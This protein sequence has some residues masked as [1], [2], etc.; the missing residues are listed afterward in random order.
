MDLTPA[1]LD[2]ARL[3]QKPVTEWQHI[4]RLGE[5]RLDDEIR[6]DDRSY[7]VGVLTSDSCMRFTPSQ[8]LEEATLLMSHPEGSRIVEIARWQT[9]AHR[10]LVSIG[11]FPWL[12]ISDQ[13]SLQS[14]LLAITYAEDAFRH[15]SV[16]SRIKK[17]ISQYERF[18]LTLSRYTDILMCSYEMVRRERLSEK[19][20]AVLA[21]AGSKYAG[22]LIA[23]R[24]RH[25]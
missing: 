4:I 10:L 6:T 25:N 23:P 15:L 22:E 13:R 3:I 7:L 14:M 16:L 11:I 20:L 19:T 1:P 12:V 24:R 21:Q 17:E 9:I 18:A 8:T 5:E 2:A